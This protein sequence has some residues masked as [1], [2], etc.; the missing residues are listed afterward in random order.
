VSPTVNRE[1][2]AEPPPPAAFVYVDTAVDGANHRNHVMRLDAFAPPPGAVDCF[3][4]YLRYT[5]DLLAYLATTRNARG[6]PSVKGYP[7]PALAPCVPLDFDA[8]HDLDA[9]L[10]DARAFVRRFCARFDVPPPA[11]RA[12]FSGHKGFSLELPATLFGTFAPAPDVAARLK[13][14]VGVLA[15]GLPTLDG[16]IY[17]RVRL[18]RVENTLHGSSGLYKIPLTTHELLTLGLDEIRERAAAPRTMERV[19]DDEWEAV[20]DL[21]ALWQGTATRRPAPPIVRGDGAARCLSE[22]QVDELV[23]IVAPH[24]RLGQKHDLALCLAGYLAREGIAE[25]QTLAIV[26]RLAAND[27]RPD[28]RSNAA[29]DSYARGRAGQPTLGFSGLRALL[30]AADLHALEHLVR[31]ALCL[32]GHENGSPTDDAGNA[33]NDGDSRRLPVID[34]ADQDLARGA[35]AAWAAV[36]AAND[37]PTLFVFGG[38]PTRIDRDATTGAPIPRSL[39]EDRLRHRLARVAAYVRTTAKGE[40]SAAPPLAVVRDLLAAPTFPLPPLLTLTEVPTFAPDGSLPPRPGYHAPGRTFYAPA[41]GFIVPDIPADPTRREIDAARALLLDELL[42]DFPFASE[43][44][45]AH[46]LALLLV[47][48]LRGLVDGPTPLHL[49]EKPTA[50]TG[51]TL[52]ADVVARVATGRPV[53]AMTEGRDEDEWRKRLTARLRSSPPVVLLDNLRRPLDSAV[54][55]SVLTAA[56]FEDRLLGTSDTVRLPVRCAWVA[57][58]NNPALSAEIARRAVRIRLDARRDRPWLRDERGFRHHPLGAWVEEERGRLVAACLTLGRAWVAAGGPVPADAPTLGSFEAWSRVMAGVLDVAGVGGFLGNLPDFYDASDT[59]GTEVRAF[60]AAWWDAHAE[61]PVTVAELFALATAPES[62]LD[63]GAKSEQGQ[64]VRLGQLL[65][66]LAG[67]RYELGERLTV[68]VGRAGTE[69]R[70]VRW[71]LVPVPADGSS[72]P[73]DAD[74]PAEKPRHNGQTVTEYGGWGESDECAAKRPREGH[75]IDATSQSDGG[76]GAKDS[77]DS[78][79]SPQAGPTRPCVECGAAIPAEGRVLYCG[80]HGGRDG[81]RARRCALCNERLDPASRSPFCPDC[82]PTTR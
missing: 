55:S 50:G 37:P 23:A 28:D 1:A 10:A 61:M 54:L 74:S 75:P 52:L 18:W 20:P 9:A 73:P 22:G 7:G 25:E 21:V 2:P 70:A 44:E 56:W 27:A 6:D 11:I 53:A 71:Q 43:A 81:H 59:E 26:A 58:G 12:W 80:E 40:T 16:A 29:R 14:L 69:K 3:R 72:G 42:V 36:A 35:A 38:V 79:D 60:L 78:P 33:P 76:W 57:T 19:P 34:V 51:A 8:A 66:S 49:I 67:R 41:P 31:S 32:Q 48:F 68:A 63:V 5:D 15:E 17:E 64:K 62:T 13:A 4:T 47:P 82:D 24:W 77:A 65:R 45:R 46:A 30:D 39:T